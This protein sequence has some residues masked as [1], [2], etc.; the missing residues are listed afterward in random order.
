MI[1]VR[2]VMKVTNEPLKRTSVVLHLDAEGTETPPILT[3][4]GG[5]ARFDLPPASGKVLVSGVERYQGR[6]DGEILV[7][8]WSITPRPPTNPRAPP[9]SSRRGA[10]PIRA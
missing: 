5:V 9:A 2:V 6:L 10:M 3:D 4:R 7:D 1:A 8:L